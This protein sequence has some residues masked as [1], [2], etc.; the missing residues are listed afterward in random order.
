MFQENR[1]SYGSI[2]SHLFAIQLLCRRSCSSLDRKGKSI[3]DGHQSR[4]EPKFIQYIND[5]GQEWKVCFCVPYATV[6]WKVGDA[7]EH[8]GHFK[9]LWY[10]AKD[11]LVKYK[12]S[13]G[14][15]SSFSHTDIMPPLNLIFH[16]SSIECG[17]I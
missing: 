9:K 16:S 10:R 17:V 13:L 5:K 14:L 4:L 1:K 11:E 7:S 15:G 8:N 6:L 12:F 3:I 2:D